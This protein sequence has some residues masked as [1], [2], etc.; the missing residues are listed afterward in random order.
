MLKDVKKFN[1]VVQIKLIA[2]DSINHIDS[3]RQRFIQLGFEDEYNLNENLNQRIEFIYG[4]PGTGK[5]TF[6]L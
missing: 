4:P 2:R 1:G 5:T 3:L 6:A